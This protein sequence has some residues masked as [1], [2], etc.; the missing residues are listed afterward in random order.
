MLDE[1]E[2]PS[3]RFRQPSYEQR[4]ALTFVPTISGLISDSLPEEVQV[5]IKGTTGHPSTGKLCKK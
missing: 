2:N 5:C 3:V 1:T 4:D